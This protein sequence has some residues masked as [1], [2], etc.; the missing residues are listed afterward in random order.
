[1]RLDGNSL[2]ETGPPFL[3]EFET[4]VVPCRNIIFWVFHIIINNFEN[5]GKICIVK[6]FVLFDDDVIWSWSFPVLCLFNVHFNSSM[7]I[8]SAIAVL[9]GMDHSLLIAGVRM[10]RFGQKNVC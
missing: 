8:G 1:M 4:D 3:E 2:V 10:L 9:T 7:V 6:Q 5:E